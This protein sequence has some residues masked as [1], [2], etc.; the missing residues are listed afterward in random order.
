MAGKGDQTLLLKTVC[1]RQKLILR[2]V[3][4]Q[5][6]PRNHRISSCNAG[7]R[8]RYFFLPKPVLEPVLCR[9]EDKTKDVPQ[10]PIRGHTAP[11][12]VLHLLPSVCTPMQ[13]L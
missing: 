6:A 11:Q 12:S 4:S 9:K 3:S 10:I 2:K 8:T 13:A 1:G 5:L 7:T